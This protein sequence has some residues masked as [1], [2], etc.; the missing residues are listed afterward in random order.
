MILNNNRLQL[1]LAL[2]VLSSNIAVFFSET[3]IQK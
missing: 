3:F 1:A 2:K